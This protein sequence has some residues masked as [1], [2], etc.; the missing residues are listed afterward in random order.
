MLSPLIFVDV[1]AVSDGCD[2]AVVVAVVANVL[3]VV[4][5]V[6]TVV[7]GVDT[8]VVAVAIPNV[9]DGQRLLPQLL[10]QQR[11]VAVVVG[12]GVADVQRRP[13]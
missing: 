10:R 4:A 1:V 6:D 11:L 13:D 9:A 8:S 7:V 3:I 5:V 12:G 2:D